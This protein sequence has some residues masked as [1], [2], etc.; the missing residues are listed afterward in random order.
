MLIPLPI[1]IDY[2]LDPLT[3]FYGSIEF[4]ICT[5]DFELCFSRANYFKPPN[6]KEIIRTVDRT[7]PVIYADIYDFER[8]FLEYKKYKLQN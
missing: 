3:N 7:I 1:D 2:D 5:E 8:I 4:F 6:S